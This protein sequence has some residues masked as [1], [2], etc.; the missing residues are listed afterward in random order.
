MMKHGRCHDR[1]R[2][3]VVDLRY[4]TLRLYSP[5]SELGLL[6]TAH[7]HAAEHSHLPQHDL[8]SGSTG[9]SSLESLSATASATAMM[10]GCLPSE[11]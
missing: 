9:V 1:W 11:P 8:L 3:G 5:E 10:P 7:A 6:E 2:A 4:D